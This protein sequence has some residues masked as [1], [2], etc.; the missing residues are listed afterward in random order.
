MAQRVVLAGQACFDVGK[1]LAELQIRLPQRLSRPL[2]PIRV[3]HVNAPA[4]IAATLPQEAVE[5]EAQALL[6]DFFA[7]LR[8][9]RKK[10]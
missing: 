4:D 5:E 7:M 1:S 10:K 2:T 8:E 9:K 6:Q 3:K